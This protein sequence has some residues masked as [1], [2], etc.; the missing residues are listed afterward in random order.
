MCP[1][2]HHRWALVALALAA[3]LEHLTRPAAAGGGAFDVPGPLNLTIQEAVDIAQAL[4]ITQLNI[5]PG[6]YAES[7]RLPASG[8]D[9]VLLSNPD[10]PG[11]VVIDPSAAGLADS[12]MC[13]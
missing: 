2:P 4:G 11:Q 7:I 10:D 6:I 13:P 9:L 12:V 3:G 1:A 5:A 8:Y